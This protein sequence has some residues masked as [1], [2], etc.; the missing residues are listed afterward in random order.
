MQSTQDPLLQLV[1]AKE[2]EQF[3]EVKQRLSP[4]AR[5][6]F[7]PRRNI[8]L[9]YDAP[10]LYVLHK[11]YL[12]LIE[13]KKPFP[14]AHLA[15]NYKRNALLFL[16]PEGQLHLYFASSK[17]HIDTRK[18]FKRP[19]LLDWLYAAHETAAFF[20]A[21]P[22]G[23]HLYQLGEE[24]KR[25]VKEV[26]HLSGKY[27]CC[28]YEPLAELL[29][30]FQHGDCEIAFLFHFQ[31]QKSKNWFRSGQVEVDFSEDEAIAHRI[32]TSKTLGLES[33]RS[34][35]EMFG[36]S[37]GDSFVEVH[38]LYGLAYL[39]FYSAGEAKLQLT[40]LVESS[41]RK[42]L[43]IKL[44][45]ISAPSLNIYDNMVVVHLRGE[46]ITFIYEINAASF[47]ALVAPYAVPHE[48]QALSRQVY[49][50]EFVGKRA[51]VRGGHISKWRISL[52]AIYSYLKAELQV[53]EFLNRRTNGK[54][55]AINWMRHNIFA[56]RHIDL[57]K[58]WKAIFA[59]ITSRT[60]DESE[61]I[62]MV[63]IYTNLFYTLSIEPTVSRLSLAN[64]LV[65]CL[66]QAHGTP[67]P[68]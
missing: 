14:V 4:H 61:I 41:E 53:F 11:E 40:P 18:D 13:L 37:G 8:T 64:I 25:G 63:E 59:K 60:Y 28:L 48:R 26:K 57:S 20:V 52:P 47:A 65:E 38:S 12:K 3:Q 32:K 42:A 22:A 55:E 5:Y 7:N 49:E 44:P 30:G 16:T 46:G 31:P 50:S 67:L 39:F 6:F 29:V 66:R 43:T 68:T 24:E 56:F 21:E 27:V 9:L 51:V 45:G 34:S 17:T 19:F 15:Y 58:M 1:L 2:D 23:I 36:V 35:K 62:S 33:S 10:L 54:I